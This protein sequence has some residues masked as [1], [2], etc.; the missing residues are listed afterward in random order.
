MSELLRVCTFK[1]L[2]V[3]CDFVQCVF[4]R[5]IMSDCPKYECDREGE[6]FEKCETCEF[7]KHFQND[8]R[9]EVEQVVKEQ[10]TVECCMK[11]EVEHE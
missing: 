10:P 6:D 5:K 1:N 7:I 11:M 3:D 4:A 8:M 9:K 2:C